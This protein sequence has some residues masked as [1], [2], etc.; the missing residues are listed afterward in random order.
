MRRWSL[1]EGY[2]RRYAV[3]DDGMV[4]SFVTGKMLKCSKDVH[5][6]PCCTITSPS[7]EH[8]KIGVHR[9]VCQA[10]V[11][12]PSCDR[13]DVMHINGDKTDNRASNLAWC[14]RRQSMGLD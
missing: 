13:M 2:G 12:K 14:T 10:F 9:L 7:G 5:G 8:R 1:I 4:W 11:K 3:S 6:V